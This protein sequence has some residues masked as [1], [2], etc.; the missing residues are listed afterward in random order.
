M[1][2]FF[3][4]YG[5]L[6]IVFAG[7]M[8]QLEP[9]KADLIYTSHCPH[10]HDMLNCYI[11]L[12]GMHRF[13]DDPQ[14]GERLQRFRE[15]RAILEDIQVINEKCFANSDSQIPAG[16]Q[17]ATSRNREQ[18]SINTAVF[19]Q[20]CMEHKT[21]DCTESFDRALI[22]IM[23]CLKVKDSKQVYVPLAKTK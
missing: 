4:K 21:K 12:T 7:D 1:Q 16:I 13:K 19:K 10:F 9:I 6:N 11:E 20:Y 23:D 5:G 22:V 14:W 8:R 15:G 18:D 17:V 2:K 3:L